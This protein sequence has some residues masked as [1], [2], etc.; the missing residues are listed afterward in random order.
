MFT[1]VNPIVDYSAS[2]IC[3][4]TYERPVALRVYFVTVNKVHRQLG[5]ADANL[6]GPWIR[7]RP[8]EHQPS[9]IHLRCTNAR[10]LENTNLQFFLL[11]IVL[12]V[13]SGPLISYY[14]LVVPGLSCGSTLCHFMEN[15]Q[16]PTS[17]G[18]AGVLPLRI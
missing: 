13:V 11:S 4:H 7:L 14:N 12:L 9:S 10:R 5:E 6:E 3:V 18:N 8:R 16:Q 15:G 1:S 17:V 2:H